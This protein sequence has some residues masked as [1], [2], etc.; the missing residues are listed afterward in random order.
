MSVITILMYIMRPRAGG[1]ER[2][3]REREIS[4]EGKE[5]KTEQRDRKREPEK[6]T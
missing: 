1:P 4:R 6:E 5:A 2:E 3:G